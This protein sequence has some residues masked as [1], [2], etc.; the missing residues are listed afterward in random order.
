MKKVKLEDLVKRV[1]ALEKN[2]GQPKEQKWIKIGD[3]EWLDEDLG[4][5]TWEEGMKKCKELGGR[6]P[7]RVELIDLFDN[8]YEEMK[9]M[10]GSS[11][12]NYFWSATTVSNTTYYGWDVTLG[13]GSTNGSNKT[14][15]ITIRCVH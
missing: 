5:M 1:E 8:H 13:N 7:T 15:A 6:L 2:S 14:T 12:G 3:L 9:K 10:L 4:E 11:A